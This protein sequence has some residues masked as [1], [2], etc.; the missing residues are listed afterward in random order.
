MRTVAELLEKAEAFEQLAATAGNDLL[1]ASYADLARA[2]RD[3]AKD[4][5]DWIKTKPAQDS[6]PEH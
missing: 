2:Y 5:A 6:P 4:M 1:R 3:V